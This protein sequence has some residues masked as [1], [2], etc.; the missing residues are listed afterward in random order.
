MAKVSYI[1]FDVP[2]ELAGA[3]LEIVG[4][5]KESG[6]IKKGINETTKSIERGQT[7]LVVIAEDVEPEE[8]VMHLPPLCEEK[9]IPYIYTKKQSEIGAACG[10][11]TG[12]SSVAVVD[13]GKAKGQL[14]EVTKKLAQLAKQKV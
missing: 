9:K 6:K 11:S 8:I 3:A 7:Q 2:S 5:A 1:K 14:E 10:L 13:S 12:C 4:E